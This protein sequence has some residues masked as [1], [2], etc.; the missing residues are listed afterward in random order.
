MNPC[1]VAETV[2]EFFAHH[3]LTGAPGVG[4]FSGGPDSVA[5]AH[6]LVQ[7]LREGAFPKLTLA[8]VNHQLRGPDSDA[9]ETFVRQLGVQ[10]Q[11]A[12]P[13]LQC[14]T[15]RINTPAKVE[16]SGDNLESAARQL[17][18]DWLVSVA[19]EQ[20]AAWIATGHTADDQAETILFRLLR[21]SGLHGLGGMPER[22]PLADGIDLV[23]PLLNVRRADVVAYLQEH[24][25]DYRLDAS[26]QDVRF[27]RNRLRQELLPVLADR[28]NPAIIDVL[29]RLGEQARAVQELVVDLAG[30][31]LAE[32][33]LP[34]AGHLVILRCDCLTAAPVHLQREVARLVWKREGWPTGAMTFEHWDRF[35]RLVR[36]QQ[37]VC[38]F[39]DRVTAR[40]AGHVLQV[41]HPPQAPG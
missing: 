5:L 6:L 14:R 7:L 39:P 11:S 26:N 10:W 29:N 19:R 41:G 15:T 40:R 23:R 33:E 38:D 3:G 1:P 25:L 9:D 8:H 28:F 18:Y 32:A 24:R 4:A 36:G 12:T 37:V 21:G 27:T 20:G 31:L 30:R 2:R 34:R 17:R 13:Q 16:E 22:R 35:A